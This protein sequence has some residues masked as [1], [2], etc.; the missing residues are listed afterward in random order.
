MQG[1]SAPRRGFRA[2]RHR[3]PLASERVWSLFSDIGRQ[4]ERRRQEVI[5]QGLQA[6]RRRSQAARRGQALLAGS[7]GASTI[8]FSRAD[9][10]VEGSNWEHHWYNSCRDKLDDHERLPKKFRFIVA[11]PEWRAH[12][13]DASKS[14]GKRAREKLSRREAQK[15]ASAATSHMSTDSVAST[16]PVSP[17]ARQIVEAASQPKHLHLLDVLIKDRGLNINGWLRPHNRTALSV[18]AGTGNASAIA[19]L[20][21]RRAD[22]NV[23]DRSRYTPLHWAAACGYVV[24]LREAGASRACDDTTTLQ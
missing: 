18:A 8:P 2:G 14:E 7:L 22:V 4:K 15:V 1:T 3:K 23:P 6:R 21:E 17:L 10:L 16:Q 12:A 5:D 19:G 24:F 20:V 13:I 9:E 11:S